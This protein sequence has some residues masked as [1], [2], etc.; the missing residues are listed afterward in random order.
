MEPKRNHSIPTLGPILRW[1]LATGAIGALLGLLAVGQ[2]HSLPVNDNESMTMQIHH[3]F[4][5]AVGLL[6]GGIAG[7][8][9]GGVGTLLFQKVK[10]RPR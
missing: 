1:S 10:Q 5:Q 9:V 6:V 3:L 2:L 7:C 4:K 8:I